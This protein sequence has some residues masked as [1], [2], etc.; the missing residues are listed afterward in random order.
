MAL[1]L[2]I[3]PLAGFVGAGAALFTN[4]ATVSANAF[5]SGTVEITTSPSTAAVTLSNM[6][7]GDQTTAPIL[8][9]NVG[10]QAMRYAVTSVATNTDSKGLMSALV[11]TIKSSVTICSNAGFA[12][13][14]VQVYSGALGSLAPG[15][16]VIG[17]PTAGFQTGDRPLAAGAEETLCF[18]VSLPINATAQGASTT[19]KLT[20][21]AEQTQNN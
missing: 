21:A 17:D 20:F 13:D 7:P 11:L 12:A 8:V 15:I 5:I 6:A 1:L 3:G 2:F 10:T 9:T 16:N 4:T 18:N 19:A 14:G